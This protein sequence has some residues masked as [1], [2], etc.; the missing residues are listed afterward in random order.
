MPVPLE[1][2]LWLQLIGV[3]AFNVADYLLTLEALANGYTEANPILALII[4][5]YAF[6]LA[7]LL[8]VPLLLIFIWQMRYRVGKSLVTLAWIPFIGYFFLMVY[9]S[10]FIIR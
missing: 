1:R 9:H 8:L 2:I 4:D 3:S 6:H 10:M 5:T 7:K